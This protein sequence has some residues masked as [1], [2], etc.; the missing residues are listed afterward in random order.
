MTKKWVNAILTS[1]HISEQ[2]IDRIC[3]HSLCCFNRKRASPVKISGFD[4][5]EFMV[6]DVKAVLNKYYKT[7]NW[8]RSVDVNTRKIFTIDIIHFSKMIFRFMSAI[9]LT[10]LIRIYIYMYMFFSSSFSFRDRRHH[11]KFL[12]FM[13]LSNICLF[14]ITPTPCSANYFA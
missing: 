14:A 12:S 3:S 8:Q 13:A 1:F 11:G 2:Q 6:K 9:F 5:V 4:P 7:N 10:K